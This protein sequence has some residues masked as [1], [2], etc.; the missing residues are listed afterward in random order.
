MKLLSSVHVSISTDCSHVRSRSI[1]AANC[2]TARVGHQQQAVAVARF[3]T[4]EQRQV[5]Q[6]STPA[7]AQHNKQQQQQVTKLSQLGSCLR[8]TRPSTQPLIYPSN[9]PPIQ[10][11]LLLLVF[12]LQQYAKTHRITVVSSFT[13]FG[14]LGKITGIGSFVFLF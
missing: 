9:H 13:V 14:L 1:R 8:K 12:L 3:A 4:Y 11:P 2:S 5:Q 10:P 6:S 7:P